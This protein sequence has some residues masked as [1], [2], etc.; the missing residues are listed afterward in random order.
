MPE[1]SIPSTY[2]LKTKNNSLVLP[3][4]YSDGWADAMNDNWE[5]IDSKLQA[6]KTAAEQNLSNAQALI[7]PTAIVNQLTNPNFSIWQRGSS[8]Y[9]TSSTPTFGCDS[10]K[11]H[12]GAG[13]NVNIYRSDTAGGL[14]GKVG[15]VLDDIVLRQR[16]ERYKPFRGNTVT[17][18]IDVKTL[19]KLISFTSIIRDDAGDSSSAVLPVDTAWNRLTVS[20]T[21]DASTTKLEIEITALSAESGLSTFMLRNAV[22]AYGSFSEVVYRPNPPGRDLMQCRRYFEKKTGFTIPYK[23]P[24]S[25]GFGDKLRLTGRLDPKYTGGTPTSSYS[26]TKDI[27]TTSP[28]T[29]SSTGNSLLLEFDVDGGSY[30]DINDYEHDTSYW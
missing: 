13:N 12:T 28:G 7:N 16:I 15:F 9:T 27:T 6:N 5:T 2:Y 23:F 30:L 1:I 18:S 17:F 22:L 26:V 8:L 19:G 4:E 21:I 11:F 25:N 3:S 29:I 24:V 20:R 10:W 14:T